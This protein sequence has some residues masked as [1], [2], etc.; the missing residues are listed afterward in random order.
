MFFCLKGCE[1]DLD[2]R[3]GGY[4]PLILDFFDNIKY[5]VGSRILTFGNTFQYFLIKLS[6]FKYIC[7]YKNYF[8]STFFQKKSLGNYESLS[9]FCHGTDRKP[10]YINDANFENPS[11]LQLICK[12]GNFVFNGDSVLTT[13]ALSQLSCKRIQEPEII[14]ETESDCSKGLGAD[15]RTDAKEKITLVKVGWK[16][17]EKF[18]EQVHKLK[19]KSFF[20]SLLFIH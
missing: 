16:F 6:L 19:K 15:G 13:E 14:R 2:Q 20:Y 3:S 9:L 17:D 8:Q 18:V 5:P 1:I 10:N 12:N 4:P 7:S 11:R